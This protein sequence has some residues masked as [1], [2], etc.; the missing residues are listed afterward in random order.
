MWYVKDV[1]KTSDD[2]DCNITLF[3][4]ENDAKVA[5]ANTIYE[6][7]ENYGIEDEVNIDV[8]F[9]PAE[10]WSNDIESNGFRVEWGECE[11]GKIF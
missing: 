4:N 5:Y 2:C 9:N 10:Y 11:V 6:E 8:R 1:W 3:E 7:V